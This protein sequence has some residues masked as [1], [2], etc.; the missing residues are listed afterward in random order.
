MRGS[1]DEISLQQLIAK[2]W[3][4]RNAMAGGIAA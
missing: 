4:V 2:E 1:V 3:A